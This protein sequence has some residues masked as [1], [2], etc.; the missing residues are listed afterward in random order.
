MYLYALYMGILVMAALVICPPFP[1]AFGLGEMVLQSVRLVNR[2]G[3]GQGN[4]IEKPYSSAMPERENR[5]S[6]EH[7][8]DPSRF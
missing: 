6:C 5:R 8:S 1:V 7:P 4:S 2:S 3:V